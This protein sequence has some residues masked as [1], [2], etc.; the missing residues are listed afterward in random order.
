MTGDAVTRFIARI[1]FFE[2]D[3]A[4]VVTPARDTVDVVFAWLVEWNLAHTIVTQTGFAVG[5]LITL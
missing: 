5:V 1:S 2:R 3:Q 4:S